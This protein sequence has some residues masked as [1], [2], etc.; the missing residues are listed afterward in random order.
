[1]YVIAYHY[2]VS[3]NALYPRNAFYFVPTILYKDPGICMLQPRNVSY[4]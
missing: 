2:T 1:M 4:A 3:S